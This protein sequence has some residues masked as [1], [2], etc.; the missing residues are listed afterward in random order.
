[1]QLHFRKTIL[2]I[3]T[4]LVLASCHVGR[5]FY[6]NFADIRDFKKFPSRALHHEGETFYFTETTKPISPK[7]VNIRGKTKTFDEFLDE[8]NTVAFLIIRNDILLYEKYYDGYEKSSWV[9]SF[10][11]AKSFTS[12]LIGCAIQDGYIQSVQDPITKYIPNMKDS[13]M[14][15][16]TIEHVLQMSTGLDFNEGYFNP[17]GDVAKFYYGRN[18]PKYVSKMKTE[19]KP[20]EKFDYISGNTQILGMILTNALGEKSITDYFQEKIWGPLGMEYDAS[21]S[22]DREKNGIEKT[23]CCVNAC[24]RDFAKIGR[25]YLHQGNWQGKQLVPADWVKESTIPSEKS[26]GPRYYQYQW[27]LGEDGDYMAQGILGQYV[28]VHPS[29]NIILVR[30][31]KNEGDIPWWN[32]LGYLARGIK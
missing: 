7:E 3:I 16:I 29:R 28:Y 10:S 23:F 30:L 9:P 14:K 24:A 11:M 31:G 2:L 32:V 22:L 12:I 26:G 5:F 17:F 20:G 27:W 21:W 13:S 25:L 8:S 15:N 1:V 6:F 19:C 18:L 4:A